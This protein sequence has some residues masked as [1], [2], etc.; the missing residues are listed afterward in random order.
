MSYN[1]IPKKDLHKYHVEYFVGVHRMPLAT[2]INGYIGH[3]IFY[4]YNTLSPNKSY[5][6]NNTPFSNDL[7]LAVEEW[8]KLGSPDIYITP[9]ISPQETVFPPQAVWGE[10]AKQSDYVPVKNFYQHM[11]FKN[12]SR[13][14]V[15]TMYMKKDLYEKIKDTLKDK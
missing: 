6:I 1:E 12:S 8:K 11:C 2:L 5:L 3:N 4:N 7:R 13:N 15:F 10:D 14:I 9:K